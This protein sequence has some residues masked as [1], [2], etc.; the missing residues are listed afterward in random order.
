M[1]YLTTIHRV[2]AHTNRSTESVTIGL[3]DAIEQLLHSTR[4]L[5][6]P[7]LF[8]ESAEE[9]RCL[10]DGGIRTS[11]VDWDNLVEKV[12]T[13]AEIGVEDGEKIALG[14]CKC[15][16]Q[17]AGLLQARAILTADVIVV[18]ASSECSDLVV[19]ACDVR[20]LASYFV[21]PLT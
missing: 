1:T 14:A 8:V 12:G 16:A 10:D 19:G 15:P 7:S 3:H 4:T 9:L 17:I 13:R 21:S 2:A 18:E 5:L 11:E 6:N 20:K